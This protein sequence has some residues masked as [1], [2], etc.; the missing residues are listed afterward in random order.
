VNTSDN[1]DNQVNKHI[2]TANKSDIGFSRNKVGNITPSIHNGNSNTDNDRLLEPNTE[3]IRHDKTIASTTSRDLEYCINVVLREA[4]K[5]EKLIKQIIYAMLSAFT[6]NPINLAINAPPGEGK[7]HALTLVGDLFPK[8]DAKFISGMSSKA[9]FH[10]DGY[11]AIRNRDG[12]LEKVE[13]EY[14]ELKESIESKTNELRRLKNN[15]SLSSQSAEIEDIQNELIEY[16]KRKK[17]IEK[18]AVKVIELGHKILI[19]LDTPDPLIFQALM[20]LLSHDK[21]ESE[22]EYAD[23]S[24]RIG[25]RTKTNV[26]VGWPV[27]IFAQAIDFSN[28]ER[29][30]EIQRRFI[31]TNPRM[32]V[33]KYKKAIDLKLDKNCFPDFVYQLK[34]VSDKDKE[35]AREII[36]NIRD[37]IL[38]HSSKLEPGK[39]N[40]LIPYRK[41]INQIF[42]RNNPSAQD[43]THVNR[44][45]NF[46]GLL[47]IVRNKNR[48]YLKITSV[49]NKSSEIIPI[50]LYSDLSESLYLIKNS[51]GGIRPYIL[52]WYE[53][54]FV[55]LYESKS[56][57][58]SKVK[59]GEQKSEEIIAVTIKEL[60][61]KT[62][63]IFKKLY[64]SKTIGPEFI[65]PL[66]NLGYIDKTRSEIDGRAKIYYPVI[67]LSENDSNINTER[68]NI[69]LFFFNQKNNFLGQASEYDV[70]NIL[71]ENKKNI[72]CC[73]DE[74][75]KYYS[76]KG[77]LIEIDYADLDNEVNENEQT[78]VHKVEDVVER[79]FS[80]L[81]EP[82]DVEIEQNV[83]KN[84]SVN[85]GCID[86]ALYPEEY[87]LSIQN[88]TF[89]HENDLKNTKSCNSVDVSSSNLFLNNK[90]NKIIYSCYWCAFA[91]DSEMQY[92]RHCVHF[93]PGKPAYPS[94]ADII[95]GGLKPQ[96]KT[97]E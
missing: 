32:D 9:I 18:N 76:E 37:D 33:E 40:I 48:P 92:Q 26:L 41:L 58:D 8:S 15:D 19:F 94:N 14:E 83:T 64:T 25:I 67:K 42:A 77:S 85:K 97:W 62:Y 78:S 2:T 69:S 31:I 16:K 17:E 28:H 30:G 91:T 22:Y 45:M 27:V 60:I 57:P 75:M 34:V 46:L 5:E 51:L 79:Y 54:V 35:T 52:D 87:S 80:K 1:R 86:K 93:H 24:D 36:L 4:V 20:P 72:I 89:L 61:V 47:T 39:N 10:K 73:I 12:N 50:S 70:N 82:T 71:N 11:T 53:K 55:N 88:A 44:I 3:F 49:W 43:I 59:N 68:K 21:Y 84:N 38:L 90:K 63:E 6:T 65:Y 13:S 7:T 29:Y 74:V 95:K 23:T 96:G 66:L 56:V 81:D